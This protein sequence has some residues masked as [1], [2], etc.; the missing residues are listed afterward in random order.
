MPHA[1]AIHQV[2]T[3]SSGDPTLSPH[4]SDGDSARHPGSSLEEEPTTPAPIDTTAQELTE[5][6]AEENS[7]ISGMAQDRPLPGAISII[8]ADGV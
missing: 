8:D 4:A 1:S 2:P 6:R 5:R 3:R 7:R